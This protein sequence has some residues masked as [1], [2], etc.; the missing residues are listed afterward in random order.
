MKEQFYIRCFCFEIENVT[1]ID[2]FKF[3]KLSLK[4]A[5]VKPTGTESMTKL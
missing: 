5:N 2:I 3:S 4:V 1:E